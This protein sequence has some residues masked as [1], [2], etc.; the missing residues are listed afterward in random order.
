MQSV[1]LMTMSWFYLALLAPL[2]YAIVNLLDDNLLSFVYKSPYLACVSVGFFGA[3]PLLSRFFIHSP[4]LSL[5]LALLAIGAGMLTLGYYFFYFKGLQ[6]DS[7]S[8]VIALFSLAPATIPFFA[9]L[10]VHE[11]LS[12]GEIVGFLIVLLASLGMGVTSVRKLT[13][14]GALLPVVIAVIMLDALS[15]MIKYDYQRAAFYPVYLYFSIGMGLGSLFFLFL[16]FQENKQGILEIKKRIK[17]LLPLFIVAELVGLGAEL[18]LNLA[19]SRG[20]VSLVKVIESIQPMFV[21]LIAL[22]LYPFYPKLFREAKEGRLIRKFSLM[23]AALIGL[24]VIA[25]NSK[26]A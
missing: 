19:I 1:M 26:G 16:R 22:A 25:L 2:M 13:F 21:L 11:Q 23:A 3:T 15:I 5:Q 20:P 8:V 7:P 9:H 6:A 17:K 18:T 12:G 24:T 4:A 10:I 14:S